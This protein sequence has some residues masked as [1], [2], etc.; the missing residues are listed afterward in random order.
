MSFS[1]SLF[2]RLPVAHKPARYCKAKLKVY[3]GARI[4]PRESLVCKYK[5]KFTV[6]DFILV[7]QDLPF[8]LE[9]KSCLELDLIKKI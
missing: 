9:L 6:L 3:D 7:E 8:V 1:Q 4:T 5:G 2:D